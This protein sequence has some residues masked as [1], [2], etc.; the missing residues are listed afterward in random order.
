MNLIADIGNTRVKLAVFDADTFVDQW[1]FDSVTSAD[2]DSIVAK[3]FVDRAIVSSV[4]KDMNY[5]ELFGTLPYMVLTSEVAVPITNCYKTPTTLGADRLAGVV[6]AATLF[7]NKNNLVIDMGTC[8]TLDFITKDAEYLGGAIMPGISMKFKALHTF[9]NKLPLLSAENI[10]NIDIVGND[11]WSSI[12]SGVMNG[13]CLEL[14]GFVAR[15]EEKYGSINVIF[16]GGDAFNFEK[17]VNF[18]N[19]VSSN[20]LLIGLNKILNTNE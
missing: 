8:I 4:G 9:T 20:L 19:F 17:R 6:G 1:V 15:Y 18:P 12:Y 13:T 7:P 2:I 16:T 14:E 5:D 10:E 3:Y 11:T